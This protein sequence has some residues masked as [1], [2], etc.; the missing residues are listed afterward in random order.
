MQKV[1]VPQDK[2]VFWIALYG[3][4]KYLCQFG[5]DGAEHLFK[6]IDQSALQQFIFVDRANK[7]N[8]IE[9]SVSPRGGSISINNI[10]YGNSDF[11]VVDSEEVKLIFFKRNRVDLTVGGGR[12]SSG[13]PQVSFYGIGYEFKD[14]EGKVTKRFIKYKD[15]T[16]LID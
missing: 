6:E 10:D 8:P 7:V 1:E 2:N 4:D 3:P 9:I 14:K 15:N 12:M 13:E 16:I 5:M 11:R